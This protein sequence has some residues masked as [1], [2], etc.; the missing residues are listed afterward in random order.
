MLPDEQ[1]EELL[2]WYVNSSETHKNWTPKRRI[3]LQENNKWI[4]P[5]IIK[6]LS[7]DDLRKK[8]L[9]YYNNNTRQVLNTI[10]RARIIQDIAKFEEY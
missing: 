1:I 6:D 7:D 4:Q 3:F 8:F 9:D 10:N 2:D 5:E